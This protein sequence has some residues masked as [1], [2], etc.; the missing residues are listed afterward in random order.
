MAESNLDMIIR[1]IREGGN[2][3]DEAIGDLKEFDKGLTNVEKTMAGTRTTI[4]K[5]DESLTVM[6]KNVGSTTELMSG[7]GLN[8]PISPMQLFGEAVKFGS[9][10]I[11]NSIND[12]ADYVD[13]IA[14][15][16]AY[17]NTSTEEMSKMYQIADDLRIPIGSLEMALKKMSENGIP[18]SI[19]G[20]KQLADEYNKLEDPMQRN[21]FLIDSFGRAY[22]DMARLLELGSEGLQGQA[23]DVAEWMLVTGRSKEEMEAWKN[24]MDSWNDAI[25]GVQFSLGSTFMPMLTGLLQKILDVNVAISE[26]HNAWLKYVPLF[27]LIASLGA[28]IKGAFDAQKA[29]MTPPEIDTATGSSKAGGG[30]V[31]PGTAY[32]VGEREKEW[33]IPNAPGTIVPGGA[34]G[35][36][37]TIYVNADGVVGTTDELTQR[38]T[39]V[40]YDAM[41]MIQGAVGG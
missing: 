27:R 17:T 24:S 15:M 39:P 3:T 14:R 30:G 28:G 16:A 32:E 2:V 25:M 41:R 26:G 21:Q 10:M 12:Y 38:L 4:G 5:L 7:L 33:F 22:Q 13:E 1:T 35:G 6:G 9:E 34:G 29:H 11:I 20:L 23:D 40:I 8:I 37:I 19:E 31:F 18:P 36:N